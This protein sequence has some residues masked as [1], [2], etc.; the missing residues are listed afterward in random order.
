MPEHKIIYCLKLMTDSI[1]GKYCTKHRTTAFFGLSG[2]LDPG[3]QNQI[4]KTGNLF[5]AER[6]FFFHFLVELIPP[7]AKTILAIAKGRQVLLLTL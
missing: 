2:G 4:L 7:S 1:P 5:N 6:I 3:C